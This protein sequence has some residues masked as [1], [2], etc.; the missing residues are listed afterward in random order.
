MYTSPNPL[1]YPWRVSFADERGQPTLGPLRANRTSE[2]A[3]KAPVVV[4]E[5]EK[6]AF[7]K[8]KGRAV[9]DVAREDGQYLRWL[10]AQPWCK[11]ALRHVVERALMKAVTG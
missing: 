11:P 7:G 6:F 8:H 3:P 4:A 1:R 5:P 2:A 9:Q 10:L